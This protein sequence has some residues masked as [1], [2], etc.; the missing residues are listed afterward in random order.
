MVYRGASAVMSNKSSASSDA[1]DELSSA[2]EAPPATENSEGKPAETVNEN[3]TSS[4][5]RARPRKRR[6]LLRRDIARMNVGDAWERYTYIGVLVGVSGFIFVTKAFL[7]LPAWIGL[8]VSAAG[9]GGY[10]LLAWL[11]RNNRVRMDKAGD[12][13][14]YLG[15]TFT[16]ASLAAV[17][18]RIDFDVSVA[19]YIIS[20][21]G[22][23]IGSTIFGII[24][25]LILIQFVE[26]L[27]DIELKSRVRLTEAADQLRVDLENATGRFQDFMISVQDEVRVSIV[28]VTEDQVKQQRALVDAVESALK[29]AIGTMEQSSNKLA[30]TLNGH[31]TVMADFNAASERSAKAADNLAEKVGSIELPYDQL[32]DGVGK[33]VQEI[34]KVRDGIVALPITDAASKLDSYAKTTDEV[35]NRFSEISDATGRIVAG[36]ETASATLSESAQSGTAASEAL[37]KTV[38][39]LKSDLGSFKEVASEYVDGMTEVAEALSEKVDV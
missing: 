7:G 16:L 37:Q 3:A 29:G 4:N 14:Y 1:T 36:L 27:D 33:L 13:C 21:F 12:N 22:I 25:R 30:E 39:D 2:S 9:I 35:L 38:A 34:E 10:A 18:V 19:Q 17:L 26:E 32:Q 24:A 8:L 20:G 15:L 23:A 28:A 5:K 6:E 31:A 11:D